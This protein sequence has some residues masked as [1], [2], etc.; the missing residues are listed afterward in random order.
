MGE[1]HRVD[2]RRVGRTIAFDGFQDVPLSSPRPGARGPRVNQAV[3][4]PTVLLIDEN[5]TRVG[6][7]P[8]AEA[9]ERARRAELDLVEVAPNATPPVCRIQD[10]AKVEYREAV[11]ARHSRHRQPGTSRAG[12]L[13]EIKLRPG[14]GEHDYQVKLRKLRELLGAG[15]R[16]R[17]TVQLRGRLQSRPEMAAAMAERII[18]DVG[19]AATAD[20]VRRSANQAITIL[21]PARAPGRSPSETGSE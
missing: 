7:V 11:A 4:A 21:T 9:L 19:T 13:R 6:E 14:I 3:R 16:V 1:D 20:P 18:A 5:G 8:R 17:L 12:E 2:G 15:A 10:Q